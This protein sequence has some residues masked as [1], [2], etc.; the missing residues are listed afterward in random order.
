[1]AELR[2]GTVLGKPVTAIVL[3][4]CAPLLWSTGGV[5]L[6]LLDTSAWTILFWRGLFMAVTVVTWSAI[7]SRG[8]FFHELQSSLIHG[9]WVFIFIGLSFILYV[10]SMTSTTIADSLLIQGTAPILIVGLGWIVLGDRVRKI[11]VVAMI[12]VTI[13]ILIILVPSLGRGGFTGNLLGLAKAFTF[14]AG[15]IAVRRRRSVGLVPSVALAA[16]LT[17]VIAAFA[18][19]TLVVDAK[20]LLVLAYLGIFQ[21]GV[22]FILFVNWSGKIETSQTGLLVILEAVL[23]PLWVWL[24]LSERPPQLTLLGGA[25]IVIALVAHTLLYP[26][27][28]TPV[29]AAVAVSP[30]A[31]PS[32]SPK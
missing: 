14:A 23:G 21:V 26:K 19:P 29:N 25:V 24:L 1:M 31:P 7:S 9:F 4:A 12:A 28:V 2:G 30:P 3:T 5:G 10:L 18:A 11:T 6:R 16:M 27:Q 13:G 20:S 8:R 32:R 17:A 22:A 15:A